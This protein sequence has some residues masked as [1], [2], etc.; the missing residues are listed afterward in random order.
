M[1]Y[2]EFKQIFQ[3]MMKKEFVDIHDRDI[4]DEEFKK[5]SA[6]HTIAEEIEG[7]KHLCG[8]LNEYHHQIIYCLTQQRKHPHTII[9]VI[10]TTGIPKSR[11]NVVIYSLP[12]VLEFFTSYRWELY[13]EY[14]LLKQWELI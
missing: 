8:R 2:G 1:E 7:L 3:S 14:L 6:T 10:R 9:L 4:I 12:D 13:K 5:I 11:E